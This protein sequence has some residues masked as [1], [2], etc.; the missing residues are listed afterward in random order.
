MRQRKATRSAFTRAFNKLNDLLEASETDKIAVQV[1][2]SVFEEKATELQELDAKIIDLML[3]DDEA[4]LDNE[5]MG[6]EDYR[7]KFLDMKVRVPQIFC[8]LECDGS[9]VSAN[10]QI[11]RKF[12]L[13]KLELRKFGGDLKEWLPFWSQFQKIDQDVDIAPEDKFQ[14]LIQST[15]QGSRA[16]EVVESFPP[17][18]ENYPKAVASLK[19]RFGREDMLVEVYVREVLKLILSAHQSKESIVLVSLYDKLESYLRAL[20]TLGVTTEKYSAML[21]PLIESCFPEEFLKA[22]HRSASRGQA[23]DAKERLSNLMEFL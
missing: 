2:F 9:V 8:Q 10:H 17:T 16:R 6:T 23:K 12:K 18:A 5:M 13:P 11:E 14:Y 19:S 3:D 7:S 4:D 22:W 15:T 1:S 20:E 21:F